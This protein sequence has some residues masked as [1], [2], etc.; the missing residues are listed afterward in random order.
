MWIGA[1]Q[2]SSRPSAL[3]RPIPAEHGQCIC[4]DASSSEVSLCCLGQDQFFQGQIRHRP[5]QPLVL[6]FKIFQ[7]CELKPAHPAARTYA[8]DTT[9]APSRNCCALLLQCSRLFLAKLQ[10]AEAS[11]QSLRV[12]HIFQQSLI[13]YCVGYP[14]PISGPLS[15]P[16]QWTKDRSCAN[17]KFEH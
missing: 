16:F 10:P 6:F 5:S 2:M 9:S 12:S 1:V 7:R 4:G 13:L 3:I 8:I 11:T 14:S 15:G 17:L